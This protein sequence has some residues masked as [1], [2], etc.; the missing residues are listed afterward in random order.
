MLN[1]LSEIVKKYTEATK[2]D[3]VANLKTIKIT[4]NM[5]AM[6]MEMPMVMWMKNPNKIKRYYFQWTGYDIRFSMEKKDM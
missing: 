1:L 5:S 3:K 6:G 2:L 4:G